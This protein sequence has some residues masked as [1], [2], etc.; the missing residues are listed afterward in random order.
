MLARPHAIAAN[1]QN[2]REVPL[3]LGRGTSRALTSCLPVAGSSGGLRIGE[4]CASSA[5]PIS[6]DSVTTG[7]ITMYGCYVAEKA[8]DGAVLPHIASNLDGIASFQVFTLNGHT[9]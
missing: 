3:P 6:L 1:H 2:A 4:S 9:Q 5:V 8:A 7:L